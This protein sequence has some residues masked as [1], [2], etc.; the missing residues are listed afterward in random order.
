MGTGKPNNNTINR[1][2]IWIH[3]TRN[4]SVNAPLNALIRTTFQPEQ[5]ASWIS[6]QKSTFL[7]VPLLVPNSEWGN[8]RRIGMWPRAAHSLTFCVPHAHNIIFEIE[9]AVH[10]L[11][12]AQLEWMHSLPCY[13]CRFVIWRLGAFRKIHLS[14]ES[15]SQKYTIA[16]KKKKRIY[17]LTHKVNI[18]KRTSRKYS[19]LHFAANHIHLF[20]ACIH[21]TS[22]RISS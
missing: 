1:C 11:N 14:S 22:N 18:V 4:V 21:S 8:R 15:T 2:T 3:Y 13:F 9:S 19:L 16:R 10:N 12:H 7:V 6:H 20:C 17:R 5:L